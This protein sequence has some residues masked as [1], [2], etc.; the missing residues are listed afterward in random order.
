[1]LPSVSSP[2]PAP[3]PLPPDTH[4][5]PCEKNRGI[6]PGPLSNARRCRHRS[7]EKVPASDRVR[8]RHGHVRSRK[9]HRTAVLYDT[10][11]QSHG[12]KSGLGRV[13][14]FDAMSGG[15]EI[16]HSEEATGELIVAASDGAA[17]LEVVDPTR[18]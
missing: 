1:M 4:P 3:G 14:K 6:I 10:V 12:E 16:E 5:P 8:R 2:P 11:R 13:D 18:S 7:P 17:D 15:C 9:T